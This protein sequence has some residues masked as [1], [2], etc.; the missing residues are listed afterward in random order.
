MKICRLKMQFVIFFLILFF[1]CALEAKTSAKPAAVYPDNIVPD[2]YP[3]MDRM[4]IGHL[5]YFMTIARQD[6]DDFS[7]LPSGNLYGIPKTGAMQTS[8]ASFRYTLAF[9][10]YFLALE[11]FHKV[12]AN[13]DMIQPLMDRL[14]RK[15]QRKAVWDY[16]ASTSKGMPHFEPNFDRPYPSERDPIRVKNIMYSGHLA[17]MIAL[18]EKLYL[19]MKWSQPGSIVFEWSNNEKYTYDHNKLQKIIFDQFM[20][21]PDHCIQCE[22]NVC[23]AVCNQHPILA[24]LLYDQLHGTDYFPRASIK[25]M[26]WF[27]KE[28]IIDPKDHEVSI[29]WLVKQ[30]K[31]YKERDL[32]LD[33]WLDNLVGPL[34]AMKLLRFNSA[35]VDGWNGAFMN[36][37]QPLVVK[38]HYPFML[39]THIV[40]KKGGKTAYCVKNGFF[41]QLATPFFA[42]LAAEMGDISLRDKM[43]RWSD[44]SFRGKWSKDGSFSYPMTFEV[45]IA[46]YPGLSVKGI[47]LTD[48]AVALARANTKDGIRNLHLQPF[49]GNDPDSPVITNPAF[50]DMVLSRAVYD[51]KKKALIVSTT[52]GLDPRRVTSLTVSRLDRTTGY[53]LFIDG[54]EYASYGNLDSISIDIMLNKPHDIVLLEG[55]A[56]Q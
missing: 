40:E 44:D 35:T 41:N 55:N 39:K 22:P 17:Q 30:K 46:I 38:Q 50:P 31:R 5:R 34:S 19:D 43:A 6:L 10:T 9:M 28:E 8:M 25:L 45:P 53:R 49:R 12:P 24:H 16:W 47:S 37:W 51:K 21:N 32:K 23:F 7:L 15:M 48:K 26:E 56:L 4:E 33:N 3:Q 18:Y 29:M 42:V 13:T 27:I 2:S 52:E 1:P 36:A 20:N 14:I 54:K 11:Q